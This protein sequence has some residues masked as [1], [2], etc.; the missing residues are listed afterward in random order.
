MSRCA[1]RDLGDNA[2]KSVLKKSAAITAGLLSTGAALAHPGA[3][4]DDGFMATIAHLLGEHGYL[5]MLLL[6]VAVLTWR[7]AQR[8]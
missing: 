8:N 7:R 2:M 3:H 4:G 1:E 6:A 5:L